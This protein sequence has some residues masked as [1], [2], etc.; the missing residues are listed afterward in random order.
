MNALAFVI[1][2]AA[3]VAI[4]FLGNWLIFDV[5]F[6][7]LPVVFLSAVVFTILGRDRR[8]WAGFSVFGGGYFGISLLLSSGNRLFTTYV[9]NMICP[10][11]RG[12]TELE[13]WTSYPL[14]SSL[15]D[16]TESF[17]PITGIGHCLLSVWFAMAAGFVSTAISNHVANLPQ[18]K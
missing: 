7:L 6:N 10:R 8:F 18:P 15:T 12:P 9:L 13:G 14:L 4:L 16:M 1:A 3:S 11:S 17:V 2:M 5:L